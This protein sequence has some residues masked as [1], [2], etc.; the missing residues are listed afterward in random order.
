MTRDF[1]PLRANK[2]GVNFETFHFTIR[3]KLS[4]IRCDKQQCRPKVC[5]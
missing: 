1:D 4:I 3:G 2:P 5:C